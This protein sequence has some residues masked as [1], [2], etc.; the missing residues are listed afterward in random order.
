MEPTAVPEP[1]AAPEPAEAPGPA[2]V[3]NRWARDLLPESLRPLARRTVDAVG[4]R[5]LGSVRGAD[6][7]SAIALTLDDGPDPVVTPQIMEVLAA[8][9]GH[10]TFFVLL[11]NAREHP[12]IV[13]DLVAAG[14]DVELHG[15]DHRPVRGMAFG[16]LRRHLIS[17]RDELAA[18]SGRPVRY[19]RPTYG[20]QSVSSYAATR[21]AGL[22][23]V[24]WSRDVADWEE[25]SHED[26]LADAMGTEPGG[27]LL[28][29]D[30]LVGSPGR[31]AH[32]N[33]IDRPKFVREV[34]N[35]WRA[36]DLRTVSVS[37][38]LRIAPA[39]RSVWLMP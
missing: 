30:R 2:E 34:V 9:G 6:T 37:Q 14:H 10:A 39:R 5:L 35:G 27:I 3:P 1:T 38:L 32:P 8:A 24:V 21:R 16:A 29:H 33:E 4:G 13:R 18:I 26:L 28:F 31:P 7:G 25:H 23:V 19:F 22:D 20:S 11:E 12:E 15:V 36:R 17:A